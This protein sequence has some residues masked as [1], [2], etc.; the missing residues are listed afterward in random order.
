ML[1]RHGSVTSH[2]AG[3]AAVGRTY[4][5]PTVQPLAART[6]TASPIE[7]GEWVLQFITVSSYLEQSTGPATAYLIGQAMKLRRALRSN[8]WLLLSRELPGLHPTSP[9]DSR[10][11]SRYPGGPAALPTM[12]RNRG[13]CSKAAGEPCDQRPLPPREDLRN[14]TGARSLE[15]PSAQKSPS[16]ADEPVHIPLVEELR[17]GWE[18]QLP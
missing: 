9:Q 15:Q 13:Q 12:C 17:R 10:Q 7:R 1:S 18:H 4:L 2:L 11:S 8:S 6:Q 16:L 5:G 14:E 3:T